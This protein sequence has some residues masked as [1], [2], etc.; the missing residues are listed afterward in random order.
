M[1]GAGELCSRGRVRANG[2]VKM[3]II[4]LRS[5]RIIH[6]SR[7]YMRR[8]QGEREGRVLT[9]NVCPRGSGERYTSWIVAPTVSYSARAHL[10]GVFKYKKEN[11]RRTGT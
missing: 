6:R 9:R 2:Q 10:L 8:M 5:A 1:V 11:R 7:L 3:V 4:H